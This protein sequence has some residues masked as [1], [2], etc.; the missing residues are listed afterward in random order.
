VGG[1]SDFSLGILDIVKKLRRGSAWISNNRVLL[2]YGK[3]FLTLLPSLQPCFAG[4]PL[5]SL[6]FSYPY[7]IDSDKLEP[8]SMIQR[9][10]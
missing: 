7:I 1:G 2:L 9:A 6:L 5:P 3:P 4:F 8:F 10:A